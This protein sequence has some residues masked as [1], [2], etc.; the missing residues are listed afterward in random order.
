M[1]HTTTQEIHI[2]ID[3]AHKIVVFLF[4]KIVQCA[5]NQNALDFCNQQKVTQQL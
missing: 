1:V 2:L 4:F 5:L 3:Y